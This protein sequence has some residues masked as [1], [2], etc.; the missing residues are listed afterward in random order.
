MCLTCASALFCN[1]NDSPS[2]D[3]CDYNCVCFL[4]NASNRD[5]ISP[6]FPALG[7]ICAIYLINFLKLVTVACSEYLYGCVCI[8]MYVCLFFWFAF[9]SDVEMKEEHTL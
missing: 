6:F 5:D 2:S 7:N 4:Y 3:Q 8:A 9:T 1:S